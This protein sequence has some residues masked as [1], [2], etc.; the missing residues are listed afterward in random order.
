M[1][2]GIAVNAHHARPFRDEVIVLLTSEGLDLFREKFV[3]RFYDQVPNRSRCFVERKCG[4]T[5]EAMLTGHHP[6]RRGPGPIAYPDPKEVSEMIDN[7]AVMTLPYLI[8][9]RLA[10]GSYYEMADAVSLIE[11]H[12]LDESY[13]ENLHPSV[14]DAY[15]KCLDEKRRE[16]EF[17]AR[18]G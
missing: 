2:G 7:I 12:D 13:L 11:A 1:M 6:G 14:R 9:F 3:P 16:E 10:G 5:V 8:Q 17:L 4:M 15:L 18:N